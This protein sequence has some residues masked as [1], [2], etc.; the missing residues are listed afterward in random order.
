VAADAELVLPGAPPAVYVAWAASW[1]EAT[2]VEAGAPGSHGGAAHQ[3][4]MGRFLVAVAVPGIRE[5]AIQAER[6]G[7]SSVGPRLLAEP[8]VFAEA[9]PFLDQTDPSRAVET[10][11]G[12]RGENGRMVARVSKLHDGIRKSWAALVA[13]FPPAIQE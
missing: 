6:V 5:Q 3:S 2:P 12:A 11:S 7:A 1:L 4:W 8:R 13:S 9:L 10:G